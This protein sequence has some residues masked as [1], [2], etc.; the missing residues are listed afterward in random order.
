MGLF[1]E[2]I[3]KRAIFLKLSVTVMKMIKG[4]D[5]LLIVSNILKDVPNGLLNVPNTLKDVP[6]TLINVSNN[7]KDVPNTLKRVFKIL[8]KVM[9]IN[10][11]SLKSILW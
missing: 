9:G 6:N 7:L 2:L 11:N 4:T 1:K 8:V 5:S 10:S 3:I